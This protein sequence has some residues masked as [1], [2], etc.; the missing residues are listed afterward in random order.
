[1]ANGDWLYSTQHRQTCKIL[2]SETLWGETFCR[3]WLVD[4]DTVARVPASSLKPLDQ[5]E[6][7]TAATIA[8]VTAAARVADA[9]NQDVLLSP[10]ESPVIPLPHQIL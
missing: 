2:D 7:P 3:V 6:P 5:L 8:Y 4:E 9:L 1:M 10:L